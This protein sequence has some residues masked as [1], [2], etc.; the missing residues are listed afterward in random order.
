MASNKPLYRLLLGPFK[1]TWS[2]LAGFYV[3]AVSVFFL[4]IWSV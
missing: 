2:W 3:L 4:S 1:D